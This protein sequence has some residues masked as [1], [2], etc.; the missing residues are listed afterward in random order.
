MRKKLFV[1]ECGIPRV[2][3]SL[4]DVNDVCWKFKLLIG[5]AEVVKKFY[6]APHPRHTPH[7]IM[8][9]R[10]PL[11]EGNYGNYRGLN[12]GNFGERDLFC[13]N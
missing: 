1:E 2:K 7:C 6:D 13:E 8:V 3:S 11:N 12:V 4:S 10:S 9:V 5:M